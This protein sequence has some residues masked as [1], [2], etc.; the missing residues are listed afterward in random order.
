MKKN[1]YIFCILQSI[2]FLCLQAQPPHFFGVGEDKL[3]EF[4]KESPILSGHIIKYLSSTPD[5][6]KTLDGRLWLFLSTAKKL[7][8]G[9]PHS[10]CIIFQ[11]QTN[12]GQKITE[13]AEKEGH[14]NFLKLLN[15]P[16]IIKHKPTVE[17][18]SQNKP[19]ITLLPYAIIDNKK[20]QSI[21]RQEFILNYFK[22]IYTCV[23]KDAPSTPSNRRIF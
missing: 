15:D 4:Q 3:N 5:I 22:S 13:V 10:I 2:S 6:R 21:N 12:N 7:A 23:F 19:K 11:L 16:E 18:I 8:L 20:E 9:K 1:I 17:N 14:K